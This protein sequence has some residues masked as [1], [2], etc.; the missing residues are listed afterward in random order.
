MIP[1]YCTIAKKTWSKMGLHRTG[2]VKKGRR[3][4]LQQRR[5]RG[6]DPRRTGAAK[7]GGIVLFFLNDEDG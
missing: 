4:A 2:G 1:F 7:D 6:N 5:K 3:P